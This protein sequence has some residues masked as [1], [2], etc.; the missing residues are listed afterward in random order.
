MRLAVVGVTG[1]VGKEILEVLTERH[2]FPAELIP[3]ASR[4]SMGKKLRFNGKDH[5]VVDIDTA[6]GRKPDFAI[7]SAGA[8]VSRTYATLFARQGTR[9]I[10][11][12]SAWRMDPE[13][14]LMIRLQVQI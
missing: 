7:F 2:I 4:R 1:L 10:D 14:K 5:E 3:V 9:V 6:L 13:V 12:S 11:N 8:E